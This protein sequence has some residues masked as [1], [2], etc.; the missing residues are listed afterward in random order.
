M[1]NV[2]HRC[3]LSLL[4]AHISI[5]IKITRHFNR[6]TTK[7]ETMCLRRTH[8]TFKETISLNKWCNV[9]YLLC[10]QLPKLK[11]KYSCEQRW[12]V[13]IEI[14]CCRQVLQKSCPKSFATYSYFQTPLTI[15]LNFRFPYQTC[16]HKSNVQNLLLL[17][18]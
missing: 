13:F 2:V 18:Q 16:W 1:V 14:Y 3:I 11:Q 17:N 10:V 4:S 7:T 15:W 9:C 5:S 12:G 6:N 8:T